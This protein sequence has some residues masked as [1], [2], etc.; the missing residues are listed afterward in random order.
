[1][2]EQAANPTNSIVPGTSPATH[3]TSTASDRTGDVY[4][5]LAVYQ[6]VQPKLVEEDLPRI[7]RALETALRPYG[8]RGSLLLA[9][10]GVNGTISYYPR[11][12]KT[13]PTTA[14]DDDPV[15]RALREL[16]P[17]LRTRLSYYSGH[18]FYRF[19]IKIKPEIVTCRP[20]G[21]DGR[22]QQQ[23]QHPDRTVEQPPT[24]HRD[25]C[26]DPTQQRGVYVPP[27]P[28]W[29]ALL[30]DP[31]CLVWDAR[32]DYEVRLGTFRNA[33]NPR[34]TVFSELVP[35]M[36][37]NLITTEKPKKKI[38]MFCTGGIRCEKAS[39]ACLDMIRQQRQKDGG[40]DIPVYHLEGGILA[41]LDT[42]PQE[43]SLFEGSCY[44]FD[45]R[46][47]VTHGLEAVPHMTL[48]HACRAPL[49]PDEQEGHADFMAGRQCAYC[50]TT[51]HSDK[52]HQRYAARQRQ[53]QLARSK[54]ELHL[55]DPKEKVLSVLG[56]DGQKHEQ[57]Q[58]NKLEQQQQQQQQEDGDI[59]K[60]HR[61]EDDHHHHNNNNNNNNNRDTSLH[62]W[63]IHG[64]DYDLDD[65]VEQHPGGQEA[66]LLGKG[67]DCTALFD[68][69]HPFTNLHRY[70]FHTV[71][72]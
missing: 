52:Q 45:Q 24:A 29:D 8:V 68:S 12:P 67:R 60:P 70:V 72:F 13:A 63:T 66:I 28:A 30:E 33:Q 61:H 23:Q 11:P 49:Q 9:P 25:L 48:C 35:W 59:R 53:I 42:V 46:V 7:K 71:C 4:H 17:G 37:H 18:V 69:Y 40:P 50:K 27:G 32:N 2:S 65:F 39:A 36:Q 20:A 31:E 47:A 64:R 55:H 3:G 57:Q 15:Q 62:Y 44:V 41:Y 6:F 34:T 26:L 54:G 38:A 10:E 21:M 43:E 1:M 58:H 56:R 16:F 14:K 51:H 19:K 22:V 5:I